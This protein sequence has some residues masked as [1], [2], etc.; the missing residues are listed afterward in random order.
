[1]KIT[2]AHLQLL[3]LQLA[4][5]EAA[6]RTRAFIIGGE[7]LM[8]EQVE[9]WRLWAP[10]T[11]LVN[12]Y[13]PTETVVG[14]CV[15]QVPSDAPRAGPIPI[16]RPIANT[17]VYV[18]DA[19]GEPVPIGV[20][21]E[22]HV[23][24]R[25][26]ARG[27]LA[28]PALTAQ[29][30]VP[31]PFGAAPG[32]RLYRTGD[33]ARWRAD[34]VLEFLGRGDDQV[35]VRGYRI[36][37][38]EVEAVLARHPAVREVV[39]VARRD[40]PGEVRLVAYIV[41]AADSIGTGWRQWLRER[42]PDPM[43]PASFVVLDE[44]PLSPNGKIDREALPAPNPTPDGPVEAYVAPRNPEEERLARIAGAVLRR[45]T[46]GVYDNLFDLGL[47]SILSI[48]IVSRAR[49]AGL[50]LSPKDLFQHPTI[51]AL[52]GLAGT[53]A[54]VVTDPGLVVAPVPLSPRESGRF[55]PPPDDLPLTGID[56]AA[57]D[58]LIAS[59]P[60]IEDLYP[61]TPAQAGMLFHSQFDPDSGV[62]LQQFTCV[63]HGELDIE[64]FERAWRGIVDRHAALRT[65]FPTFDSTRP[66]QAVY[67]QVSLPIEAHDWRGVARE[68]LAERLDAYLEA[69]R[70]RGFDLSRAPLLRL[71]LIRIAAD[72]YHLVWTCH[73]VLLDGWCLPILLDEVL[74]SYE[75]FRRGE[76]YELPPRRP[77]REYIA[78]LLAQDSAVAEDYWRRTLAGFVEPTPLAIDQAVV[79]D[80]YAPVLHAVLKCQLS[81]TAT[82]ALQ[83]QAR[84][85]GLTLNTLLQGA[86]ALLLSRY[87]GRTD[88]VFGQ[89]V[90][91]RPA[92]LAGVESM[93]GLFINT[94]PVRV[95]VALEVPLLKWLR[96][97]Q[98]DQMEQRQYE[99]TSLVTLQGYSDVPR[100]RPLFESILVFENYPIDAALPARA[101]RLGV[102]DL[103]FLEQ[104]HYPLTLF[105]VP[106]GEMLLRVGYD[107]RRFEE[108]TIE[109]LLGHLRTLLEGVATG[110]DR[111]L[112]DLPMLTAAEQEQLLR[113]FNGVRPETALNEG[114]HVVA[115]RIASEVDRLSDAELDSLLG[116]LL[117]EPEGDWS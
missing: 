112:A 25:G 96:E 54:A 103:R 81:A 16:G 92:E 38:G 58:R 95:F 62:Y 94:L 76:E 19:S 68:A 82:A 1:M 111:R 70:R 108:A 39:V 57:L 10:E 2:P 86:W 14:C 106:G 28:R 117:L 45:E 7:S 53:E 89:A 31:D 20:A 90:S 55:A 43:I 102:T 65:A 80:A 91:G 5:E 109:R 12:E 101:G 29:R 50:H 30:F 60:L 13:G 61:L 67:R 59:E 36:E 72:A 100:G 52:A 6:G 33:L 8:A 46:V 63:L 22:L 83:A 88:V 37:L 116:T 93:I 66:L 51:A 71:G 41:A 27:Y 9:F 104:S 99:S 97:L 114:G 78:W 32:G 11:R 113:Q 4:P 42:L 110:L 74:T 56:R 21:G 34:G 105:V 24:G 87:S 75:A 23:G 73:H 77:Y 84:A 115:G 47:D 49:Q 69:E 98:D 107:A 64:A 85:N 18:L 79:A 26:V 35:K 3:S 15:Y 17:R 48:Q 44:L 40:E